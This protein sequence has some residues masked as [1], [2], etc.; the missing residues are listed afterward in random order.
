MK[1]GLR[2]LL[3][4]VFLGLAYYQTYGNES[5]GGQA[6]S[7]DLRKTP[8]WNPW[9]AWVKE[10]KGTCTWAQFR[11]ELAKLNKKADS[12][13]ALRH[14]G[15]GSYPNGIVL[16]PLLATANPPVVQAPLI[17]PPSNEPAELAQK[18]EILEKRLAEITTKENELTIKSAQT[19]RTMETLKG[20]LALKQQQLIAMQDKLETKNFSAT[21][22]NEEKTAHA[23]T[24]ATLTAKIAR[25]EIALIG[26]CLSF[27]LLISVPLITRALKGRKSRKSHQRAKDLLTA[28]E[29]LQAL[30]EKDLQAGME[31]SAKLNEAKEELHQARELVM[32]QEDVIE[33]EFSPFE[34]P[35]EVM[36]GLGGES[37]PVLFYLLRGNAHGEVFPPCR[38]IAVKFQNVRNHVAKCP[39]CR[40]ALATAGLLP[41]PSAQT[42][43][44]D[45]TSQVEGHQ[46]PVLLHA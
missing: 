32:K 13:F 1:K 19:Q 4:L 35:A 40:Q 5:A 11:A 30:R 9:F 42:L 8:D 37:N 25:R 27:V 18:A 24:R 22:L 44:L 15:L 41:Q 17:A 29:E 26:G 20:E 23:L 31:L 6:R 45:Q 7:V 36:A 3:V 14:I 38:Q 28:Y 2:T 16:L 12:E 39:K 33:Q 46:V 34:I 10:Y 21:Q 43:V